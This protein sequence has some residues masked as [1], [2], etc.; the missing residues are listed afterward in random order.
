MASASIGVKIK[1]EDEQNVETL[2]ELFLPES[3]RFT[4]E[5]KL[6][7]VNV[8]YWIDL[9]KLPKSQTVNKV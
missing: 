1:W 9:K 5:K 4:E 6:I 2:A 7:D 8:Q 3:E